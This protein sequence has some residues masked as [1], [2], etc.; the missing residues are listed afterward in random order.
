M[1]ATSQPQAVAAGL[2]ILSQ[3]GNAAD[4][5]VATAAALNVTE[6]TSTGL[7]GDCFAL[8]FEASSGKITALN[9]SGRAPAKLSIERL[10][11]EGLVDNLPPFHP[12]TITVPGACAGWC[13]LVVRY[14]RLPISKVLAPAIRL[15]EQGFPVTP[16]TAYFW[17]RSISRLNSVPGGVEMTIDGRAP[18][19]GEIFRNRGLARTLRTIA[20]DGKASFYQGEIADAIA[21]VVQQAGGCLSVDDLAAHTSTWEQPISIT[22]RGLRVWECPPNGQGL[23]ALL[24]LNVLEGFDLASMPALST[25]RLHI[26]IDH[27]PGICRHPLVCGRP[28]L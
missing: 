23:A 9:G 20:E 21:R 17:N 27:A 6:P 28:S 7:G 5:A 3:G 14:G 4:A 25:Q 16:I 22:Y 13:D 19:A 15:A 11:R 26:M 12:Y 8:Y 18:R 1:V 24:A 10:N 2:E